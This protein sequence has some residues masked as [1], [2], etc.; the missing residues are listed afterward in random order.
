MR[1]I[2]SNT[3]DESLCVQFLNHISKSTLQQNLE[4]VRCAIVSTVRFFDE[5][6]RLAASEKAE[7]LLNAIEKSLITKAASKTLNLNESITMEH[8]FH[9]LRNL[10]RIVKRYDDNNVSG[11]V[12][13]KLKHIFNSL[14]R[15][16]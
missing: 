9:D 4:I 3:E 8:I 7:F 12:R 15:R 11:S 16:L 1:S 10:E 14:E 6:K 5:K 13:S 2:L